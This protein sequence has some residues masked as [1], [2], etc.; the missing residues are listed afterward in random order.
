MGRRGDEIIEYGK[1]RDDGLEERECIDG[2]TVVERN[3][4]RSKGTLSEIEML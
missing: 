4:K 1:K 2:M 3:K